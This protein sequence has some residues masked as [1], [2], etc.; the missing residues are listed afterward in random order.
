[1][2]SQIK[3]YNNN[4]S[5]YLQKQWLKV[6]KVSVFKTCECKHCFFIKRTKVIV[7]KFKKIPALTAFWC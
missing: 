5:K 3:K 2:L 1:M 7:C 6:S 4:L